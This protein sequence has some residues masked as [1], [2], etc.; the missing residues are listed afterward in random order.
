ML[1]LSFL[2]DLYAS[3]QIYLHF[4]ATLW[5]VLLIPLNSICNL[6]EFLPIIKVGEGYATQLEKSRCKYLSIDLMSHV[7]L[8]MGKYTR[9]SLSMS[10]I[11]MI[12]NLYVL[13]N[14][15]NLGSPYQVC[16][17]KT[18]SSILSKCFSTEFFSNILMAIRKMMN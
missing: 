5:L 6:H 13:L 9:I 8:S 10:S 14:A 1:E 2:N 3:I 15:N 11:P 17:N 4:K 7:T 16:K 18:L 12:K